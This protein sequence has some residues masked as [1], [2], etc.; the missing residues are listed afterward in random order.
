MTGHEK[1]GIRASCSWP[2]VFSRRNQYP[3]GT[4]M[5]VCRYCSVAQPDKCFEVCRVVNGKTYRRRKCQRCKQAAQRMRRARI[6]RW[7]DEYKKAQR[8]ARCGFADY[9]AL[10]FHHRDR[11]EKEVAVAEM[12]RA[13]L[14]L[15]SIKREI[16]KCE[17]LCAN[18]H[19][20]AHYDERASA[21]SRSRR[22]AGRSL[23]RR[24][25]ASSSGS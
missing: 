4:A 2:V 20:I 17:V 19:C 14:S 7:V 9:R 22:K 5:M 3:E 12:A 16:E 23:R 1:G 11:G 24:P 15:D 8:C 6:K 13:G 18:C 10:Q 21:G 25:A